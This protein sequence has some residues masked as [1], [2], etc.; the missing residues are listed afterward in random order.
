MSE[1]ETSRKWLVLVFEYRGEYMSNTRRF[2]CEGCV[3]AVDGSIVDGQVYCQAINAQVP[4]VLH[5]K[6]R[7]YESCSRRQNAEPLNPAQAYLVE[8]ARKARKLKNPSPADIARLE[9][10]LRQKMGLLS[11]PL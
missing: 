7:R 11:E 2:L 10:S 8:L 3:Y 1:R 6:N 4:A 5:T 9:K